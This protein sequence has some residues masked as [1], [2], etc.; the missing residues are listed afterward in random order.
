MRKGVV[1]FVTIVLASGTAAIDE[2]RAGEDELRTAYQR[3]A[4]DWERMRDFEGMMR[5]IGEVIQLACRL[6][7]ECLSPE[8]VKAL[9]LARNC[10][11][12]N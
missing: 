3:V 2:C 7:G 11:S 12:A 4:F 8:K 1:L 6:A 10:P 5:G 9:D